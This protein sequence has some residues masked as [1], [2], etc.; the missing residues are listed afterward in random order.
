VLITGSAIASAVLLAHVIAGII[1][2][3]GATVSHWSS[4]VSILWRRLI[5]A[6]AV[7]AG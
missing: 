5:R 1:T 7:V 6:T 4:P 3:P 2:D